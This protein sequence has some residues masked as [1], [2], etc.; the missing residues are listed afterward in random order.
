MTSTGNNVDGVLNAGG[1]S[2]AKTQPD[3]NDDTATGHQM[4]PLGPNAAERPVNVDPHLVYF[5]VGIAR[6]LSLGLAWLT[7]FYRQSEMIQNVHS[8]FQCGRSG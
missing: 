7:C 2:K 6:M 5:R 8:T 3:N 4:D 1:N